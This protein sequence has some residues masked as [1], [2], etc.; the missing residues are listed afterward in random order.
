MLTTC[1]KGA[2]H[3][4]LEKEGVI[5]HSNISQKSGA[6]HLLTQVCYLVAY[7]YKYQ[8]DFV[9]SHLQ[10]ANIISVLAQYFTRSKFIIF[11]HHFKFIHDLNNEDLSVNRNER[12]ADK[13]INKLARKLI[14]PS[15]GVY[16]GIVTYESIDVNKL[17]VIPYT[18]KFLNYQ[19]VS[20]EVVQ[21]I[22]EHYKAHLLIV[23]CARLTRFK[24]H[25]VAF[26]VFGALI[27]EGFD[28]K[29][30]VMDEGNEKEALTKYVYE[31]TLQDHV[32]F[33]G[34]KNNILEYIAAADLLVHPSVTEASNS[35]VKE[36]A[37][38]GTAV[39]VCRGVGD[40]DSYI[41][42]EKN[43]FLVSAKRTAEELSQI[44][45]NLYNEKDALDNYA[46]KLK[47]T[48]VEKF[49]ENGDSILASYE[50][51]MR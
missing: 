22:R 34:Y 13:V 39:A 38:M 32:F 5:T 20:K 6:K 17:S 2:L 33:L 3:E 35:I 1:Q 27:M 4:Y 43:G 45:K 30:M 40:F 10:Q 28:I 21:T 7:C 14:V 48:V 51:L 49:G 24:R 46:S 12:I 8:I 31:N 15:Q 18:Y 41:V 47:S 16:D 44:I 29:V 36:A 11:R 50:S 25:K 9:F 23:M 19:T 26:E 42:H 37:F